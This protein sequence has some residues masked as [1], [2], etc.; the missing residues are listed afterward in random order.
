MNRLIR[1]GE[2]RAAG[3]RDQVQG[4][5]DQNTQAI[6]EIRRKWTNAYALRRV[7]LISCQP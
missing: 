2:E 5:I 6:E 7:D 4:W 1:T 3:T